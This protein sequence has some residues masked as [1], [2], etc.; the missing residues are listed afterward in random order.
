MFG[1]SSKPLSPSN[2]VPEVTLVS[3]LDRRTVHVGKAGRFAGSVVTA[4]NGRTMGMGFVSTGPATDV[5]CKRCWKLV[6]L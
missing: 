1:N 2:E 5:T 6:T 4:C 3:A